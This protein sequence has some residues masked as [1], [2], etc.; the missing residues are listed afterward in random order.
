MKKIL[1]LTAAVLIF[2]ILSASGAERTA[3]SKETN[4]EK[5]TVKTGYSFMPLPMLAFD[6]AKGVLFGAMMNIYNFG[7]GS[8]YP[9]PRCS[10]Y[11]DASAYTGGSQSYAASF[12]S[13]SILPKVRINVAAS[14]FRDK[15]MEFFGYNGSQSFY[16]TSLENGFYYYGRGV[17]N[18][19]TDFKGPICR[20]L[21]WNA[22]YNF[23]YL[24]VNEYSSDKY[25]GDETLF[26]LYRKWGILDGNTS[27]DMFSSALKAGLS[28]DSRDFEGVP[29]RG[30]LANA[31][32]YASPK[33]L[34]SSDSYV[35]Y[36]L[37][38]QQF[39]PI[40]PQRL[41]FV[42][43]LDYQDFI[44][45]APWYV[46]P[47]FSPGGPKSD[48]SY[49]GGTRMV[50]GIRYNRATGKGLGYFNVELRWN[51]WNFTIWNQNIGLMVSGF[52]DGIHVFRQ[53]DLTNATGY[54]PELYS[55]FINTSRRDRMHISAGGSLKVIFNRNFII[56]AEIA[57][58]TSRQDGTWAIYCN[59]GFYF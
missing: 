49:I 32:I 55:K 57:R 13:G 10:W 51:F 8:T 56:N 38:F 15:A 35:K 47:F 23:S 36:N 40:V 22:G 34:G 30:I 24:T 52:C 33:F 7:D 58:C 25:T 4:R 20:N 21:H 28:Y 19:R 3:S 39:V 18:F 53:Y 9:N 1:T 31:Y 27:G 50:R 11:L 42:Y 14:W 43:H 54:A 41:T 45:K 2:S 37:S 17:L 29:G 46:V 16:D 26:G 5:E 59:S 44:G 6:G 12:D 48:N